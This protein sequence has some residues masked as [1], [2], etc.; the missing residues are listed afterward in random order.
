MCAPTRLQ[1]LWNLK[2]LCDHIMYIC[3]YTLYGHTV[4]VYIETYIF[5]HIYTAARSSSS[6]I[7]RTRAILGPLSIKGLQV[8]SRK[9]SVPISFCGLTWI[10]SEIRGEALKQNLVILLWFFLHTSNHTTLLFQTFS[11][12]HYTY[13]N[14]RLWSKRIYSL[15]LCF[16]H[17]TTFYSQNIC[18]NSSSMTS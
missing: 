1:V 8:F 7:C 18:M 14:P 10:F 15:S 13:L 16:F 2:V 9:T 17:S 3:V 5:I 4:H 6:R 12:S 11:D